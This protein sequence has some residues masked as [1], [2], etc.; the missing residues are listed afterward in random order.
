[1]PGKT[2]RRVPKVSCVKKCVANT[3][4]DFSK[5]PEY[6]SYKRQQQNANDLAMFFP[7]VGIF[8]KNVDIEL[9]KS[10]RKTC[11]KRCAKK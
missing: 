7:S 6:K 1:M 3:M 8:S 9:N 10:V 2:K 11:K 4:K 5:L